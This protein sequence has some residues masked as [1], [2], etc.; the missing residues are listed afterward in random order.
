MS[1]AVL[2]MYTIIHIELGLQKSRHKN[3][4]LSDRRWSVSR[5]PDITSLHHTS[6]SRIIP[7]DDEPPA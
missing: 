1:Y 3:V 7:I 4:E 5:D 6:L 2:Y